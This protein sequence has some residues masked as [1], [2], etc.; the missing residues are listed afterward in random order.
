MCK[1]LVSKN[2]KLTQ[3]PQYQKPDHQVSAT[4]APCTDRQIHAET[5]R[6]MG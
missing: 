3:D 2:E 5:D 6:S 1:A 4:I